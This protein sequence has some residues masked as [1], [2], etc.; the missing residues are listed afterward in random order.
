[1]GWLSSPVRSLRKRF[2]QLALR[3][4]ITGA[5]LAAV[6]PLGTV[7]T[8]TAYAVAYYEITEQTLTLL[9]ARA[10]LEQREIELHL[11]AMLALAESIA[12]N[13][14][15]ANALAD[16][17]GREV[18]LVPLLRNQKLAVA[19]ASL[20]I[21]DYRGRPI[22]GNIEP[23]PDYSNEPGFAMMMQSARQHARLLRQPG[24]DAVVLVVLPVRYRLTGSVEGGV[25]LQIPL[26]SLLAK[27]T[28]ADSRWL[29][30]A[31]G[32]AVA[33]QRLRADAFEIDIPLALPAPLDELQLSLVLARDRAAA[34]H[35]LNLLLAVFLLFGV[36]AVAGVAVFARAGARFITIP[37]GEIA[38]AAEEIATSGRPVARLP[39]RHH[40][41][42]GRLSAAFNTMVARLAESYAELE[43][44]V[45]ERTRE[46]EESRHEAE[47]AGNLLRES[48]AS[49]A[50]GFTIYDENDRLVLC[51]EAYKNFYATSRDLIEPGNTFEQIVRRGAERGQYQEAIGHI[52]T[53]VQQRVAQHQNADGKMVEQRLGDGRW[54]LIVEYR[55]PS[56]YIVGNRIDITEL[57]TTAETL[58]QREIHF[59][60]HAEQLNAIFALSPDGFVT[61]DATH[62][63]KYASPAFLNLT[64]L[65]ED[66]IAGLD[67]AAFS[68]RLASECLV[69]A[70]FTGIA[71]LRAAQKGGTD[72]A[73]GS[74][75]QMIELA[76]A[77]KRVL[78]VGLRISRAETVSQI[79]YF[80][81]ITHETEVD[82]L[83]SE[84][85]S[86]A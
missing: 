10:Q 20:S 4:K 18:Y 83:K 54:L 59:L 25:V 50:Q 2:S 60:E 66:E 49:I 29:L 44:R 11:G 53:W 63:V 61:F 32:T 79:L 67:E 86:T 22:A 7:V 31:T 46:Y 45:A 76:G 26:A 80:R 6:L 51:N 39:E 19:G 12:G 77:S 37:L 52:D 81:D 23:A 56:G 41:E 71:T 27:S 30:N 38:A 35:T 55:T 84:F 62:R 78:Q 43:N 34:L 65:A 15:T 57:K 17:R 33:G 75:R 36:V 47:K 58:R 1:M 5:L 16:S 73:A 68:A 3:S 69:G 21:T 9:R 72:E 24:Q 13:S 74:H 70:R 82:R 8:L 48:V 42:F 40:D 85:L 14:I 64:G 28:P